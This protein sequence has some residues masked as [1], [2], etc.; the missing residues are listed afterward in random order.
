[1]KTILTTALLIVAATLSVSAKVDYSSHNNPVRASLLTRFEKGDTTLTSS[2]VADVYYGSVFA[3]GFVK[4]GRDYS[5]INRLRSEGR[6]TE[7]MPLCNEA[8][9]DDPV[10]LTLLFRSF[11]GA[12]AAPGGRDDTLVNSTRTRINQLCDA[13]FASGT[14]VAEDSPFEV[15]A[16]A[17]IE[18]FLRN[19]IQVGEIIDTA[20]LGNLTVAKVRL[21]EQSDPVYLYFRVYK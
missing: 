9:K 20:K 18:Q 2:E 21:P 11:A 6:F 15:V 7:M 14:G 16:E 13:I 5:T 4:G 17:D 8:L 19:Y 1:M 3:P 12:F 10:S